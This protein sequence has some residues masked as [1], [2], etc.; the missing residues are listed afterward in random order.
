MDNDVVVLEGERMSSGVRAT[1][2]RGWQFRR[3]AFLLL[4]NLVLVVLGFTFLVPLLWMLSTSGKKVGEVFITPIQWIPQYP[5]WG[6]NFLEIFQMVPVPFGRY[7]LNTVFITVLATLGHVVSSVV[8]GYSLARLRWPGREVLFAVLLGTMM[9]PGVVTMV[10]RFIMFFKIGWIDNYLP[11]IVPCWFGSSFYIFLLRQFMRGLPIELDEAARID[12]ANTLRI[13][14]QILVPLCKPA[15]AAVC[16]FAGMSH[17]N[18]FMGPLLY[19]STNQKFPVSL[20]LYMFQSQEQTLWHL[21]MAASAV[22]VVPLTI[23]FFFAQRHFI[24]G[25]QFSGLTGR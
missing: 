13:L 6:R 17:Y 20:G 1:R 5:Q 12:G 8:V 3:R 4:L 10:P 25:I 2:L 23:L 19:L 7:I 14:W 18:N 22:T 24:R 21:Q 11:L 9:L 15:I 16:I